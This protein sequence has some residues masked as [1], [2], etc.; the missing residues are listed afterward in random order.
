MR[1]HRGS[2]R[3][4]LPPVP[5]RPRPTLAPSRPYIADALPVRL[6]ALVDDDASGTHD[7]TVAGPYDGIPEGGVNGGESPADPDLPARRLHAFLA[8]AIATVK[9]SGSPST[10]PTSS[11]SIEDIVA[12]DISRLLSENASAITKGGMYEAVLEECL[13]RCAS[14]AEAECLRRADV[15]LRAAVQAE[16]LRRARLKMKYLFAGAMF[17]RL[18]YTVNKLSSK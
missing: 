7:E 18:E 12:A 1:M 17:G 9:R 3:T 5:G 16:R 11:Q 14:E 15:V 6:N 8:S 4:I 2:G 13:A 10:E